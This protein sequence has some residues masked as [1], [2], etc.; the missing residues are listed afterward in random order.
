M[1]GN[2]WVFLWQVFTPVGLVAV[3]LAG[4][5]LVRGLRMPKDGDH[6]ADS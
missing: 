5:T 1:I 3:T 4:G 6:G 2:V